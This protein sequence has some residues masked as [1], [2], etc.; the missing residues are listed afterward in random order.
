ME[1][2]DITKIVKEVKQ[3]LYVGA[4]VVQTLI[5]FTN[6]SKP[7]KVNEVYVCI[8]GNKLVKIVKET[9]EIKS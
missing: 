7:T 6:G 2:K 4:P 3:K 5:K 9:Y 1:I 8:N